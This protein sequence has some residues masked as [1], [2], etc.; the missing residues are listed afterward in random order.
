MKKKLTAIITACAMMATIVPTAAFATDVAP[1]AEPAASVSTAENRAT[2]INVGVFGFSN[3]PDFDKV[4][5]QVSGSGLR[6]G[7]R[8]TGYLEGVAAPVLS[9]YLYTSGT[10]EF[11]F[12]KSQIPDIDDPYGNNKLTIIIMTE[13]GQTVHTQSFT[14]RY[15]ATTAEKVVFSLQDGSGT[16]DRKIDVKFDANYFPGEND[17]IR[18]EGLDS[19]GKV[20][21]NK[22]THTLDAYD[23]SD[24]VDGDN[25][26]ALEVPINVDFNSNAT[27]V[28][29]SFYS[30]GKVVSEFTKTLSLAPKYGEISELELVFD[31]NEIY[32]GE[33]VTGT[34]YYV[35]KEG[36][37]YDIT[38]EATYTYSDGGR[39]C[40]EKN[41]NKPE[42]TVKDNAT[43]GSNLVITAKYG[44]YA[45]SDS[46]LLTVAEKLTSNKVKLSTTNAKVGTKANVSFT[47]LNASGNPTKLDF[48]PSKVNFRFV[49]ASDSTAKF[50]FTAANLSSLATNGTMSGY[51][52]CDK[53][54]TG[55]IELTFSDESGNKYRVLSD[56]FTFSNQV[57]P[58]KRTVT[59]TFGS[60][61]MDINGTS[62]TMDVGPIAYQN[63]TFVPLRAIGDAFDAT[64]EWDN[65]TNKITIK[66][67]NKTIVMTLG[68]P[69]YTVNG[70]T[71]PAMD[72]NPYVVAGVN[73]TM[74]PVRFIGE[75]FG[76]EVDAL[77]YADGHGVEKVV[78]SNK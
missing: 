40:S 75:A 22:V 53:P 46:V 57:N 56:T 45:Q 5:V 67:D 20:V 38:D 7:Y 35:N 34:L 37:R 12:D 71:K 28:R 23:L 52:E 9:G 2:D 70:V 61:I 77:P 66:Y 15:A 16:N 64:T 44:T 19:N 26:R 73:R 30:G 68:S 48:K 63:R 78:I 51:V 76:F 72:V 8:I 43:Y 32:R 13:E 74:V 60:K 49:D 69:N 36:K 1:T 14:Q 3:D 65:K 42:F 54:C 41:T 59:L 39:V 21:G 50:N 25:M 47:L 11:S 17:Y 24:E 58:E 29:L 62:K 31:S 33:T 10:N 6:S 55:K 4:F 27:S 18:I